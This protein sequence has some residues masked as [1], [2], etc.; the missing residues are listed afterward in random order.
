MVKNKKAVMLADT[1]PALVGHVLLQIKDKS[2]DLFD[3]A[4][5]YYITLDENDKNIMNS[6]MPCRFI[7]YNP[8]IP[9]AHLD[10]ERFNLFSPLMFARYEMFNNLDEFSSVTWI[11][12][13]VL[14]QDSL[15]DL[16]NEAEKTGYAMLSEDPEHKSAICPDFMRSCFT[17]NIRGYNLD[18]YLYATGTIIVTDKL[19]I[20][21]D[22]TT[23]LYQKTIEWADVLS[24]PDQGAFNAWIQEFSIPVTP[25]NMSKY[26]CF[27]YYGR[28]C[29][30]ACI[31][32]SYGTNKFWNDWYLYN[33]YPRWKEYYNKWL[34]LGGSAFMQEKK[35]KVSVIMP[36]CKPNIEWIKE[37]LNSLVRQKKSWEMFSDHEIIIISEPDDQHKIKELKEAIEKYNDP[38]I[39]L[40]FNDER[41]GI[42]ASLN[43]GLRMAKGEYI[44]RCDDDDISDEFRLYK[45]VNYLDRHPDITTCVTDMR[46][47]G[48]MNEDRTIF[49]GEMSRAWSI[50][51]CPFDHPT[52]MFRKKFF[53]ENNLFY[54]ENR[55]FVEDWELWLRAFGRGMTVGC[56][57]EKLYHHRW[58]NSNAGQND[59]TVQMMDSLALNNFARLGVKIPQNLIP[60]IRPWN[61]RTNRK[62]TKQ[63]KKI[64]QYALKRNAKLGM[65]DQQSLRKAFSLRLREA[66]TGIL[67]ANMNI[68]SP[69]VSGPAI[70]IKK[71]LKKTVKRLY[72]P[73]RNRFE[74]PFYRI[75]KKL[76]EIQDE[77]RELRNSINT[78]NDTL[79]I[80]KNQL[81]TKVEQK[82]DALL[83]FWRF[84]YVMQKKILL[85]G[86]PGHANIGDAAIAAGEY[87]F[88]R[89]YF[90]DYTLIEL[91]AYQMGEPYTFLHS[92]IGR[93]DLI[94]LH[95][96]GNL[97]TLY[98]IEEE[99]RRRVISDFPE[100]KIIVF[101][102]TAYFADT[103][104]GRYE[105]AVSQDI[106]N[107]HKNLIILTRGLET[108]FLLKN[109]FPNVKSYNTGDMALILQRDFH[110]DRR[111]ILACIR[112]GNDES[113]ID[114]HTRGEIDRAIGSIDPNFEKSNNTYSQNIP[115]GLRGMVIN[116]E[117]KKFAR[118][119]V[120]VTDRLHGMIFAAVTNTPCV[121]ISALTQKIRE[122]VLFFED[123]NAVFFIDKNIGKLEN[124]IQRAMQ[125]SQPVFPLLHRQ[126]F[127]DIYRVIISKES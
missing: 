114:D 99:I 62:N 26:A 95:G 86:T 121:V 109:H 126:I 82:T 59:Q 119:K 37:S 123:S 122:F 96:G 23:W 24:L 30:N 110:L 58:H 51:T 6:V 116:E 66:E 14:L 34:N 10:K 3:E 127:D 56:V 87:E 117:L 5:I 17:E 55:K 115:P 100:N 20:A 63:L 27:P 78:L 68:F 71:Q 36:T 39:Q 7:E 97:G 2:P 15:D 29:S 94:F 124:A 11:D 67:L 101:P 9:K 21:A 113:G 53:F 105:L 44:A 49:E 1:R 118:H 93:G 88:I 41:K 69:V 38:R 12:T 112:D 77:Q 79:S 90:P 120:I 102:Q 50:F 22:Y 19:K 8:P 70:I 103:E 57:H 125:V 31:V 83:E 106:Y 104:E 89:S 74:A 4:I 18:A 40:I 48:D 76:F 111:G 52:V 16:V 75:E 81:M 42:A 92:L 80:Y 98:P 43:I 45:Q 60:F 33:K 91:T 54:D 65:Y 25:L 35:P 64:F 72:Q 28:D 85:L 84:H 107:R 61:G 13:D 32:H 47:F 46:Y 73:F 108:L